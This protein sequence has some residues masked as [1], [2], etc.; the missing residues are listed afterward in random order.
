MQVT[1]L[2]E[3][4]DQFRVAQSR[5]SIVEELMPFFPGLRVMVRVPE[6]KEGNRFRAIVFKDCRKFL[7][8]SADDPQGL[9]QQAQLQNGQS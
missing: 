4:P 8:F 7:D 3:V 1:V 2:K 9:I 6:D 5:L